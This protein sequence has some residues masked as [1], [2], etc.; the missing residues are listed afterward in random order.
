M[1]LAPPTQ[2]GRLICKSLAVLLWLDFM[3]MMALY[4]ILG[5]AAYDQGYEKNGHYF[6]W[7]KIAPH[8]VEVTR[9]VWLLSYYQAMSVLA[10]GVLCIVVYLLVRRRE[11]RA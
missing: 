2:R 7:K 1:S 10:L 5:G 3:V 8:D 9:G 6:L 4:F 11:K